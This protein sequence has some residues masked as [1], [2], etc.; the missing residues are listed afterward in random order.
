[1][2][3]AEKFPGTVVS[4]GVVEAATDHVQVPLGRLE[5]AMPHEGLDLDDRRS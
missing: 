4:D 3:P 5:G 1:V 2:G